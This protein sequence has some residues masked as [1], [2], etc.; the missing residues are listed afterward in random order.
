MRVIPYTLDAVN[1]HNV[2]AFK[3]A[4]LAA[5]LESPGAFGSTYATESQFSDGDWLKRATEWSSD[6][7]VGYLAISESKACGIVGACVDEHE[8]SMIHLISMWV[9]PSRRRYGIGRCLIDAVVDWAC[10]RNAGRI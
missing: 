8:W 4:R 1:E 10:G 5:L 9:A 3:A 2:S 7:R 6:R